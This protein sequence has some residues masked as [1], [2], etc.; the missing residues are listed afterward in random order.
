FDP[1]IQRGN[2]GVV[3]HFIIMVCDPNFPEHLL[4]VSSDCDDH[5]NM[6]AEVLKCRGAGILIAAWGVGGGGIG[7]P[8][9]SRVCGSARKE[10]RKEYQTYPDHPFVYPDHVGFPIGVE[11]TGRH[12][13]MEIHFDNPELRSDFVDSSGMRF[14][15]STK[16]TKYDAGVWTIGSVVSSWMMIPPKQQAWKTT[17]YCTKA[18]SEKALHNSSLP[19][20]GIKIF[21]SILHTHLAGRATWTQHVRDGVELPEIAR[22]YNYDFNFQDIQFL[23]NEVHI[24]PGDDI[25]H[26]CIQ[27]NTMDRDKL[28]Y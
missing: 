2:E 1:F 9:V 14:F 18:C 7:L 11:Y 24:K 17:G 27:Y 10:R 4:N 20:K 15:T 22:D 13:V 5:A 16:L 12:F 23:Q 21:S 8:V 19:E 28:S 6:P 3:H 25:I 26:N